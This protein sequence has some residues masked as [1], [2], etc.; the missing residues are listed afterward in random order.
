M[1]KAAPRFFI[2]RVL[3][4]A[5][6]DNGLTIVDVP[7]GGPDTMSYALS[8]VRRRCQL[9]RVVCV[10]STGISHQCRDCNSGCAHLDRIGFAGLGI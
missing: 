9:K 7:S 10:R 6:T 5:S 8:K 2:G 1:G 4:L 3:A